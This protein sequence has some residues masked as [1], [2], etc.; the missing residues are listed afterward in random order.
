MN[1][2]GYSVQTIHSVGHKFS[3]DDWGL[4]CDWETRVQ[5]DD[6][7]DPTE[8]ERWF[9]T[10]GRNLDSL[11]D[12]WSR[13]VEEKEILFPFLVPPGPYTRQ[14]PPTSDRLFILV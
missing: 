4:G 10:L 11:V 1:N 6:I 5:T 12:V 3:S 8:Q 9:Y 7:V 14:I 2:T 13:K